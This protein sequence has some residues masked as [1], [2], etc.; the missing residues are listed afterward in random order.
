MFRLIPPTIGKAVSLLLARNINRAIVW[1]LFLVDQTIG[2]TVCP[3]SFP[4]VVL[5]SHCAA[6]NP[7]CRA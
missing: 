2:E 6:R 5:D 4:R 3:L 7:R 1:P